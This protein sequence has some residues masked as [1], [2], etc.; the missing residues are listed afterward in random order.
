MFDIN[1]IR[2]D[3]PILKNNPDLVYLDSSATSFKPQVVIDEVNSY[4]TKYTANIHR[5]DYDNSFVVS[6]EYEDTRIVVSKLL[7]N[8]DPRCI[9][10]TAGSTASLNTI[11][12]GYALKHL[13]KDDVIL[14]TLSEH[15]SNIL[16]WFKV[17]KEVGCKI[18]YI[19]LNED[20]TFNLDNYKKCL[21]DFNVKIIALPFVSNVLGYIN[22]I[23]EI[24]AL[25]H[26]KGALVCI[27]G[28]QGVPHLKID[29]KDLD[30][31]FLSFSAHKMLGPSGIGV[32]YGK[33]ELL[34]ATEPLMMGGGANARFN[35]EAEIILK[36]TPTKF[37]AG[38]PNIEGVLGFKKA[39]EYLLDIGMENIEKHDK[40]LVNYC[41][42]K[43][44]TLKNIKIVNPKTD[45]A[46][47]AFNVEGIFAQ[48]VGSYLNSLKIAVRTGN[49]CAKVL[50]NVIGVSETIRASFYLYNT[51]EDVDRLYDALKDVTLEKCIG[52]VI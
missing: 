9:V 33:K 46:I 34:D 7:N 2:N 29:V 32:L 11:A 31:D 48:D 4:Y 43:L 38:T 30:I 17:A 49:H 52:A 3:F 1:K 27:D 10:F 14:L 47:V 25:A 24:N 19:P 6:K 26:K 35:K 51:K 44:S 37:E 22:P 50:D 23:K 28:A 12:Y 41:L 8:D 5:G 15:A 21:D 39:V 36:E 18:E 45:C 16:P 42:E 40:E 20:G 13:N